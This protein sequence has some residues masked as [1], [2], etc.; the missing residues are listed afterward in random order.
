[1]GE[2]NVASVSCSTDLSKI[3]GTAVADDKQKEVIAAVERNFNLG[4]YSADLYLGFSKGSR[5]KKWTAR[6]VSLQGGE[7][8]FRCA[9]FGHKLKDGTKSRK[10]KGVVIN[11]RGQVFSKKDPRQPRFSKL[12]GVNTGLFSTDYSPRDMLDTLNL[13]DNYK[14]EK[15]TAINGGKYYHI[16]LK[17]KPQGEGFYYRR[18]MIVDAKKLVPV[19]MRLYTTNPNSPY[20]VMTV[21]STSFAKREFPT[22][23]GIESCWRKST[24]KINLTNLSEKVSPRERNY[25]R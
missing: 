3:S 1:M 21:K 15:F 12:P 16:M 4:K 19:K 24:T 17:K 22:N 9:K 25:C 5:T 6:L 2:L 13:L 8:D 20:K 23:Y 7:D 18:E 14:I 11:K 10:E